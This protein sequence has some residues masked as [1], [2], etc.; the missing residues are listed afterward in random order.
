MP[1]CKILLVDDDMEDYM[2]IKEALKDLILIDVIG[3][4]GNGEIALDLLARQYQEDQ[5]IPNVIVLD[6]NMPLMDGV[7]TLRHL[8]ADERFANIP[9]IIYST[10][11]NPAD[12][13][14][15]MQLGAYSCV[16]KPNSIDE[17][18]Q[19]GETLLTFCNSEVS[20][21]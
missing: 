19:I 5:A 14:K 20:S 21:R 12:Q 3:Y 6:L 16:S 13:Q 7:T 2:I 11:I 4:A 18:V 8:K 15:C 1:S 9:V 17:I 10:S